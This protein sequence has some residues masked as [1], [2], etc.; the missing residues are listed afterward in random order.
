[1][2]QLLR[3]KELTPKGA[4]GRPL[5]AISISV[6]VGHHQESDALLAQEGVDPVGAFESLLPMG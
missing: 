6:V 4:M 3:R 5:N 2:D 1:M